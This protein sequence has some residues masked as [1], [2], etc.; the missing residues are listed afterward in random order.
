ML[1][2]LLF[3][4]EHQQWTVRH[5]ARECIDREQKTSTRALPQLPTGDAHQE[6]HII[7]VLG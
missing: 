6:A 3:E 7:A 4:L 1:A 2:L 5:A